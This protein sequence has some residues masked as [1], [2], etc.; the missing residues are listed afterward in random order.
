MTCSAHVGRAI[1]LFDGSA[2][3]EELRIFRIFL[4]EIEVAETE[5]FITIHHH[6]ITIF[7]PFQ[8]PITIQIVLLELFCGATFGF[9][10]VLVLLIVVMI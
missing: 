3:G 9:G 2:N 4:S 6:P 5:L 1:Y 8:N 7:L 10:F